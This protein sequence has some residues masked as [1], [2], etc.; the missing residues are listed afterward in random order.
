[1]ESNLPFTCDRT[2]R[3]F[4]AG[5]RIDRPMTLIGIVFILMF[6]CVKSTDKITLILWDDVIV[7]NRG[8]RVLSNRLSVS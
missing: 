5:K 1:M 6:F 4:R 3:S 2:L 8:R 7:E